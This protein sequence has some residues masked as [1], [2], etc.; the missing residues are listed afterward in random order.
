MRILALETSC[1]ETSAAVVQ[2]GTTVFSN[3][4]ASSRSAFERSG[5]VIPEEAAR[6]QVECVV[7]VIHQALEDAAADIRSIDTLATTRGPGLTGSLLVGTTAVRTLAS[8]WHKPVIGV[9]HTL[10]HLTSTWLESA[11]EPAFPIITLSASG[12]HSDMWYRMSHTRGM[13]LGRSRDDA[14]GEAFDK[15]AA[16]LGLPYPGGPAIERTG[17]HGNPAAFPFPLPLHNTDT[18]DFS[19]SGLKT[20]L[21]YTIRDLPHGD[22]K[23]VLADLTASYELAICNHLLD[24]LT[25]AV[26]KHPDI[27][28]IHVVGGVS[29][30]TRLRTMV[31]SAFGNRK[32]RFPV[33]LAYCTDNAAMI[34]SAA[35]FLTS[36]LGE[37]AYAPFLTTAS[38]P[39]TDVV[40]RRKEP[41]I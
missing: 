15:G 9:H 32:I 25:R 21:K 35:F 6:K 7:P 40:Q 29:A 33:S 37:D 5:G 4:I 36:E 28:E 13:L 8:L 34:A 20:A 11:E 26:A 10:G 22:S 27:Q 38:L 17:K 16:L 31:Q 3:V 1:D 41:P 14:A 30:N 18:L 12:G 19:F 23:P 2:D 24:R 39:L